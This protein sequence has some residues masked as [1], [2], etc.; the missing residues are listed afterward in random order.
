MWL[1][2]HAERR[3]SDGRTEG[4]GLYRREATGPSVRKDARSLVWL[5]YLLA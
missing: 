5:V 4:S 2:F 1:Q 3:Y